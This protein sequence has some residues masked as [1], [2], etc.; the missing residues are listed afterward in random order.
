[1]TPEAITGFENRLI[2]MHK[3]IGK[4]ARRQGITCF[5]IYD[6]DVPQ[7]PLCIDKYEDFIIVSE[8]R[9]SKTAEGDEHDQ[10]IDLCRQIIAKTLS[11]PIA[12]IDFRMRERKKGS[13]QYE[14]TDTAGIEQV[15][16]EG[17]LKF[18]IQL[19]AYLD[20]GL[21]LDHRITRGMVREEAKG[22]RCLNL[23]A[24]T[25]SFSVYCAA[26][27]SASTTTVDLSRT[28]CTWAMRN[29]TLNDFAARIVFDR[30]HKEASDLLPLKSGNL[31]LQRDVLDFVDDCP[32]S[33]FDLAV[34]D[35]PSFSNSKRMAASF[36]V[37]RDH[38]DLIRRVF[39]LLSPDGILYF[40]NN[41]T[42]FELDTLPGLVAKEITSQTVPMDFRNKRPHRC[43][44]ILRK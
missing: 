1:M 5:R 20:P 2:R 41:L 23:F 13:S 18:Q 11:V 24:Y 17:G 33:S 37:Q 16:R 10:W 39:R 7:F 36:D 38:S 42:T 4:W 15:V 26:G 40:S 21:F 27:G 29:F 6:R 31:V 28:Y 12:H 34:L 22:K 14:K 32:P 9:T 43:Y 8:Y 35:P 25:G 44:R 19:S 30:D 3:H